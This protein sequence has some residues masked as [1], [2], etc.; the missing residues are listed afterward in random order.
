V[1][2]SGYFEFDGN[3]V[4]N[5]A[6][7]EAYAKHRPWF[8]A[9]YRNEALR[10]MLGHRPYASPLQDDAPWTDPDNADSYDFLGLY[11]LDVSGIEDSSRTSNVVESLLDG[12][13]PGGIRHATK[14]VVFNGVL[15]ATSEAGADYGRRWLSRVLLGAGCGPGA[16]CFGSTLCYLSSAP[17]IDLQTV[18]RGST[19]A[20]IQGG[21]AGLTGP[22]VVSGGTATI[23]A[24]PADPDQLGDPIMDGG[25]ATT[26][27]GI[28]NRTKS[29][30]TVQ[31][32]TGEDPVDCLT[33][34]IRSLRNVSFNN[35]PKITAK[36]ALSDGSQA[37]AVT[38]TAVAG[39]PFEF[40]AERDVVRGFLDPLVPVPW[41]DGVT[42]EGGMIDLDGY[43]APD[44]SD[45]NPPV[46]GPLFDP[47]HPAI[48][49]PPGAPSVPLGH[50]TP[51]VNWRRRQFTIPRQYI[52]LWGEMVPRIQVHAREAD[53][54][55]LRIRFYADPFQLGDIS[56]DPCA[57]CG[58][59]II[60]YVPQGST[61]VL[62]GTEET[63]H[64]E[65]TGGLRQRADSLVFATDGTPFEWPRLTCGF[66]YI[67]TVDLPEQAVPPVV[68]LSL[69]ERIV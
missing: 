39:I 10:P 61:M 54:R 32:Y 25:T 29:L 33:D 50:F 21:T 49:L 35:G 65:M 44:D 12:G 9:V 23:E 58:D 42:P 59:F 55:N 43:L 14:A 1:T 47:E 3:E 38:F 37:W 56:D 41:A 52:G 45:C 6:R 48:I 63:V 15:L 2:W 68:D 8:K 19:Q 20:A 34:Y 51:P 67:V 62:D 7:T 46:P 11:P 18:P 64:V 53:A 69:I 5:V 28:L 13:V 40:T 57:Y 26:T 66:G 4:I 17:E 22:L 24:G 36:R 16:D 60:S 27:G 31:T 30:F